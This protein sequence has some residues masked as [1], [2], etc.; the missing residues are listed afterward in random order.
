[1]TGSVVTFYSYKGGVGR[2]FALANIATLLGRW[3][4]R[5]LCIDWDL[6]APGLPYYFESESQQDTLQPFFRDQT[7]GLVEILST[8]QTN[9]LERL[10]WHDYIISSLGPSVPRVSLLKAGLIDS[11]YSERLHQLDWSQMYV[12]GLG[13][14]F[15]SM[16]NDLREEYDYVFIDARTGVTDFTGIA[17]VQLPDILVFLFTANEQSFAGAKDVARRS[18]DRRS[19]LPIDAS[20]PLLLPIPSRFEVQLEHE[21]S[22]RW[23]KRFAEELR[24]FYEPWTAP[25]LSYDRLVQFTTIPYVP[26]WSFGERLAVVDDSYSDPL[27]INYSLETI[28]ALLAHRLDKSRLLLDSRDEFVSSAKRLSQKGQKD[29]NALLISFSEKDARIADE[30]ADSLQK[31]GLNVAMATELLD[32][33]VQKGLEEQ[34]EGATHLMTILDR[35]GRLSRWQEIAVRAF[36]RQAS[37]DEKVRLL[38][39]IAQD[40]VESARIPGFLMQ[41]HIILLSDGYESVADEIL[42][43]VQSAAKQESTSRSNDALADGVHVYVTTDGELP[44]EGATVCAVAENGTTIDALTDVAG[45]CLIELSVSYTYKLLIAHQNYPAKVVEH[46]SA[47]AD[48]A[49][50]LPMWRNVGSTIVHGTGYIQGLSGRLNPILDTSN[51]TYLYAN[52]VAIDGGKNQPAG[53]SIGTPFELQ[54]AKGSKFRVSVKF[55]QARTS[56]LEYTRLP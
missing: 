23:R 1:M 47:N 21:I 36:L 46:I 51:R 5:V 34:L 41:Y 12:D 31:R 39:P 14:A 40:N 27:S 11:S 44:V 10:E 15:E 7:K 26:I 25:R 20:R 9:C 49:V 22:S 35:H 16:F 3:G 55:I 32:L 13:G 42:M 45:E 28:A 6:E 2:S 24:E 50:R 38:I 19:D 37:T 30:L 48:V 4:F 43:L 33:N 18:V 54:D 29:L 52:N 53:F 56:L 8:F 17:S